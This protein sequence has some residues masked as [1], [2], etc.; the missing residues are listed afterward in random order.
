MVLVEELGRR[1]VGHDRDHRNRVT[2]IQKVDMPEKAVTNQWQ[3][4]NDLINGSW[5]AGY[6][7]GKNKIKSLCH[8]I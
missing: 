3:R 7:S 5:R 4:M 8:T 1:A 2:Q 6:P